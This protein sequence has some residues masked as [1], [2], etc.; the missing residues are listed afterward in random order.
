[1]KIELVKKINQEIISAFGKLIPQL[2]TTVSS[3][4]LRQLKQLVS[5]PFIFLFIAK[6]SQSK[7]KIIGTVTLVLYRTPTGFHARIED[8]VVEKKLRGKGVGT[9]LLQAALYKAKASKVKIVDLTSRPARKTANLLYKKL[10]FE[11]RK[12]NVYRYLF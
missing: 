4:T 2:D 3:P 12:T 5:S 8:L 6:D 10:G 7:N 1:M 9:A 11:K